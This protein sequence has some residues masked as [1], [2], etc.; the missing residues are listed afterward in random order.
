M[1]VLSVQWCDV[2]QVVG[3]GVT[4]WFVYRWG[5]TAEDRWGR[6]ID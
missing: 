4:G 5:A 1:S 3:L 2:V 6:I